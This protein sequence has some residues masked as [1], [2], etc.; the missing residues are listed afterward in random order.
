MWNYRSFETS[1]IQIILIP[2]TMI[3][4]VVIHLI[5]FHEFFLEFWRLLSNSF[6]AFSEGTIAIFSK[7]RISDF[8]FQILN[9]LGSDVMAASSFDQW[10]EQ[11]MG[12]LWGGSLWS[13]QETGKQKLRYRFGN[14]ILT[15]SMRTSNCESKLSAVVISHGNVYKWKINEIFIKQVFHLLYVGISVY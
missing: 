8:I 7:F 9:F 5:H 1:N 3:S 15:L 13:R 2:T 4:M 12:C 6:K 11:T 14:G 10:R